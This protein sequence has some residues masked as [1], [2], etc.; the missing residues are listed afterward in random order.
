MPSFPV[1]PGGIHCITRLDGSPERRSCLSAKADD[2]VTDEV[3]ISFVPR[4]QALADLGIAPE[5]FEEALLAALEEREAL[6][7]RADTGDD[8]FPPLQEM[9]L[10]IGGLSYKLEELAEVVIRGSDA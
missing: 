8:E 10:N 1:A 2:E 5:E 4:P 6:A 9:P 7:A 3:E